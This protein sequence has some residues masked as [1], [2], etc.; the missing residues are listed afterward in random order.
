MS[1][2]QAFVGRDGELAG[3]LGVVAAAADEQPGLVLLRGEAGAGKTRLL[4]EV[5]SRL[6]ERTVVCRGNGVGFLGGRIPY[7]PLVA[8][9]RSLLARLPRA[10][11]PQVVGPDPSDLGRLLPELGSTRDGPSDQARL[12]AAVSTVLDRAA[13][14]R[15]VVLVLDD[16]HC[17]DVAT[18]EVLAYLCAA[19]D[20]QRIA[21][22]V[23][24][25]PDEVD[26]VLGEWLQEV[27]RA[28]HVLDVALGPMTVAETRAQLTDLVGGD[29]SLL[30]ES[31][32]ARIHSRSGGNPYAA[33]ALMRA[34][35][36]GD[37]A[38]LPAS[39][40]EVL[41]RR[42]RALGP[43]TSQL[44]RVV[45]AAGDRLLPDLLERLVDTAGSAELDTAVDE[46]MRAQLLVAEADGTLSLRHA[47]LA[48]ALYADLLPGERRGLHR[49]LVEVLEAVP[50][51]RPGVVAE[52][53]DR[54]GDGSRALLW[55]FRA[56][57]AAEEVYAYDEAHRQFE[58]VRRLWPSVPDAEELVGSDAVEVFSRAASIAAM[59]DHDV[60]AVEIIERVRSWLQADPEVDQVRLGVLEAKYARFL[61]EN[62]RTDAALVAA[63]R[64]VD[65]VPAEPPTAERGVVVSGLV[66]VLDWAGGSA[67]WEPLADEAVDVARRTGDRAAL[68]RALVIRCTVQ[69][70]APGLVADAHEAVSLALT[71]GDSELV[72]QTFSNLVDCLQC[73]GL[74]REGLEAAS[75]GV[76]AVTDRGLGIR[77]GSWLSSQ[78]AELAL[79][80]GWWDEAETFVAAAMVHTR[81]VQGANRDYAH[82]V[83]ARLSSV[84]GDWEQVR[85]DLVVLGKLP[86]VLEQL[87]CEAEA[88]SLLWQGEPDRALALVAEHVAAST[89]RLIDLSAPLAWLGSRALADVGDDRR[90]TGSGDRGGTAWEETATVVDDLV[91]RACG[92]S[93]LPGSRPE[94]LRALCRA[95]RSRYTDGPGIEPWQDAVNA[96]LTAE[97]PYLLAYSRWRLAQ[98]MVVER[99]LGGA[100]ESLRQANAEAHRLGAAPLA[101]EI[102]AMARRTRIDLR[103]PQRV[104]SG[105][106]AGVGATLTAREQEILGHL[107]AGRTNGEIAKALVISTKTAS[108]HVSNILR[109]LDVATRYQAAEIAERYLVD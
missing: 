60:D 20:R 3:V 22:V 4:D 59:C 87:R 62:G 7:A 105:P 102:E 90:R 39:L 65:L 27:R 43:V 77:Y 32:I 1:R 109:K 19:L 2:R 108:V 52:H 72:G 25:R 28:G 92:P 104:S 88:E 5:V 76:S 67:D 80:Y 84:R 21:V 18:L 99:D 93:A 101:A 61:L 91:E 106:V 103:P 54:A 33:E 40:R 55:S 63:R 47:L 10:D 42:T 16:L 9:L 23:A 66:H 68:A 6:P 83:R 50:D 45:A 85:S 70:A 34:A 51:V 78:A 35:L 86:A 75:A 69:P 95:E 64:A 14:L 56:A 38:T 15:P 17:A 49:R 57:G 36:A 46:A 53:A 44:L 79:A 29:G 37:E 24:F 82:V 94:Q 12:V 97:R 100:A 30:G 11:V 89:D 71:D 31:L 48:E 81:H 13:E 26:E 107:A 74:G 58:R 98:A 41:V 8:A 73:A 96:L